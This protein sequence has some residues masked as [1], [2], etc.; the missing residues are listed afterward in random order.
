VSPYELTA[1][2][3]ELM[4]EECGRIDR[5]ADDGDIDF[6]HGPATS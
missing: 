3:S 5:S 6:W 4:H 1:E 2:P